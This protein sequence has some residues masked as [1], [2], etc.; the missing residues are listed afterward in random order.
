MQTSLSF[1]IPQ[2]HKIFLDFEDEEIEIINISHLDEIIERLESFPPYDKRST[3]YKDYRL[4][5]NELY[6]LANKMAGFK[7]YHTI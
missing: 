6:I 3:I 7:K 5:L 1:P 2:K 4:K